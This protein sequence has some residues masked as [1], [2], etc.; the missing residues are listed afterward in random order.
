MPEEI[1]DLM[2]YG[3]TRIYSPDDGREL[4]LQGMIDPPRESA[5]KAVQA[6]QQAGIQVKMITGDHAV[7]AQAIAR[8][9]G[10]GKNGSVLAFT[11][12]ELSKMDKTELMDDPVF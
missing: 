10:M 4:G 2:N 6:C 3:I 5:I 12:A 11:G 8:R 1:Q 9:M 7:T